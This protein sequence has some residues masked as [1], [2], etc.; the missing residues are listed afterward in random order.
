[1]PQVSDYLNLRNLLVTGAITLGSLSLYGCGVLGTDVDVGIKHHYSQEGQ[2][3]PV[4]KISE[5]NMNNI[6][7]CRDL[8]DRTI[9]AEFDS[10]VSTNLDEILS[11]SGLPIRESRV[12]RGGLLVYVNSGDE[13]AVK[14]LAQRLQDNICNPPGQEL[15]FHQ[16]FNQHKYGG[17]GVLKPQYAP[18][19]L[20]L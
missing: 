20:R 6:E 1:M 8:M 17:N 5:S 13:P 4:G 15:S 16:T 9:L 18:K 14:R 19:Q 7:E 2:L 3:E 12:N 10:I 11:S